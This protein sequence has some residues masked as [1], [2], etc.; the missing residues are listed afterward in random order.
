MAK[1]KKKVSQP[2]EQQRQK[3]IVEFNVE[4]EPETPK[5]KRPFIWLIIVFAVVCLLAAGYLFVQKQR[6]Y[7]DFEVL[8]R[9]ESTDTTQMS[10]LAFNGSLIKYSREGISYL[11]RNGNAV[12]VESYKMKQPKVVISGEY[13]AVADLNGNSVYIFNT[14]G[15]VNSM[16][17]P[18]T[19]C[20]LDVADQGVF[21]VV[22][23]NETEN[24]IELYNKQGDKLVDIL[25]TIADG[26][27]PLDIA[28]SNDGT[29]LITSYITVEGI[30]IKNS[31]AAY[32]FGDVGQNE[33]D[34]LVGGFNNLENT[35]VSKVEFLN[36]DIVCA[37]GDDRFI[38]YSMR[39]KPSEKCEINAFQEEIESIF[40]NSHF[41]G[42][43]EK[44][45]DDPNS[46]YRL[47][48][49]D[50]NGKERFS[51]GLDFT[52]QNI[53]ATEDE[54]IV[55]G[56]SESRIYD[57]LGNLKFSYAF[58]KEIKNIVPTG[59]PWKYIVVYDDATEVIKL[60][61]TREETEEA[62]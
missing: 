24:Y 49:F 27:Y 15:R 45:K 2:V 51:R 59:S 55:V 14:A 48:V 37:F 56:N 17:V 11:D 54:I 25:T 23:E 38:Y 19:I 20:N 44:K 58:S 30:T 62:Q 29:K 32:N 57:F 3:K 52:Y 6:T 13:V 10:Y 16:E 7:N 41:V 47:R 1:D 12:W 60:Q 61:Y 22:L 8:S 9:V 21:A 31:I 4:P 46:L 28:L 35:L 43:V 50:L 33:T 34:R 53:Y 26:G 18:Y 5:R 36:N 42:V 39:E 40:Y